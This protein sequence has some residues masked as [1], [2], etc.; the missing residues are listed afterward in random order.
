MS[1]P[2]SRKVE[3][4]AVELYSEYRT[5]DRWAIIVG[6]SRY[7]H[8]SLNLQYADRDAEALYNLLLTPTGG[9]FKA[10]QICKLTNEAATTGNITRALRS[11][12]KKP[13]RDDLV[14][15]Y[16]ACHGAPDVDRPGN[17]YLLTH[18]TD[19]Q[20]IAGTALPMREIDLSLRENLH[21][22]KVIVLAD[23]CH[24]A[25][26]G[27]GIGRRSITDD[28]TLM[29]RY[30]QELSRSRGG[31][32]LLTSAEANEVSFEDAKWD[33]HG[34]FTY[35]LLKGMRGEAD[36]DGDDVVTVG[37]LFEYVRDNV[38]R[39][40]D[41]RQHPAI[42]T[43]PFDRTMPIAIAPHAH[44]LDSGEQ[45]LTVASPPASRRTIS[46]QVPALQRLTF[47]TVTVDPY[48][49]AHGQHEHQ[50]YGYTEPLG[51]GV[52]LELVA[53]PAGTF[54]MGSPET[55]AERS[56][57]EGPQHWVGISPF[58]LGQYPV[59]QAQW[60]VVANLPKVRLDLDPDP[61][62]FKGNQRPVERISWI[63]AIEFC[64]RLSSKTGRRYR[65]PT[66]AEWEYACRA[67]STSPYAMGDTITTALANYRGTD[68]DDFGWSGSYGRGAKGLY[69][70]HTIE[71]GS[72]SPNAFGIYGLHGN[73]WEWCADCWHLSYEGAP[74]DGRAWMASDK[75]LG[76]L[77]GGSWDAHPRDC[78]S[79][80][81]DWGHPRLRSNDIGFRVACEIRQ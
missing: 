10:E 32:A 79:A 64:Q 18:D 37:E 80:A 81:R 60:W 47:S 39:A 77:R 51:N 4:L 33:R 35:Y 7:A 72:F 2:A 49:N 30:L 26:I 74:S 48:G 14:L 11:F 34:V 40:T 62:Q 63:E 67:G 24:S 12:L 41:N 25:A 1:E 31:I 43:N 27:G 71:I 42:G 59:T 38:K 46:P 6:I 70:Q 9:G 61:S 76:V 73:I 17:V 58:Y 53:L 8:A 28:A 66:E 16:F 15:I 36:R 23:T 3:L 29:N 52:N 21:S 19:P 55:E 44:P 54:L 65:L 22:E 68:N 45:P 57:C 20:D 5:C 50:A 69:R 13:A 56:P 75:P 78:R